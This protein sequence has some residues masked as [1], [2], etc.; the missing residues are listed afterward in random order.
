MF[1]MFQ[2]KLVKEVFA[3][4]EQNKFKNIE[5][6]KGINTLLKA[7]AIMLK[8]VIYIIQKRNWGTTAT[9]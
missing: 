1:S 6:L 9:N 3:Q 7:S 2:D 8:V 4:I 5:E